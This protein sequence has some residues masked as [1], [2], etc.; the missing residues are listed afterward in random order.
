LI[1]ASIP[2]GLEAVGEVLVREVEELVGPPYRGVAL[3]WGQFLL[4]TTYLSIWERG[5]R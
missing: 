5:L 3:V 2:L 1:Q 4:L